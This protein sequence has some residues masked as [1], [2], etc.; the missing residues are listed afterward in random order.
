MSIQGTSNSDPAVL[1]SW[2][3]SKANFPTQS[4]VYF[5]TGNTAFITLKTEMESADTA[6]G[7]I[8]GKIHQVRNVNL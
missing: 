4:T 3:D 1:E 5:T 8:S 2:C 7:L 6:S